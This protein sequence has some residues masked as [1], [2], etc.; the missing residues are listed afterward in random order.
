[1]AGFGILQLDNPYVRQF[2]QSMVIYLYGCH[3][4]LFVGNTQGLGVVFLYD[5]VTQNKGDALF[6]QRAYQVFQRYGQV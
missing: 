3:I 5:K 1:M 2:G 4:V 6:V